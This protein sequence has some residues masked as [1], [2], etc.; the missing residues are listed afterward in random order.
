MLYDWLSDALQRE[1]ETL[2]TFKET[3]RSTVRLI[4]HRGTGRRFILRRFTGNADVY[5]RLMDRTCAGLPMIFEVA[6]GPEDALVL[7]EYIQGDTLHMLLQGG[8]LSRKDARRTTI[9][10][11]RALW[12]LHSMGAVQRDV[13]PENVILRGREAVLIDFD[14]ARFHK[15]SVGKDTQILGTVGF[16]APEQ[17]GL[18]QSDARADIYSVGVLLNV[19][20]T[21]KHP[22][23]CIAPGQLGRV[24]ERCTRVNPEK[25]YKDVLHLMAA[26]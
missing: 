26:L 5:R 4:C 21:G 12:A 3:Q 2:H 20:L 8:V 1:Y 9:Q 7:E 14:A 16:A 6:E 10:V 13:K 23:K 11:C 19:M 18:S 15:P 24:V 17:Y 25:R 22:S